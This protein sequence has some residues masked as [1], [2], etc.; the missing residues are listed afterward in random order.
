MA[1]FNEIPDGLGIIASGVSQFNLIYNGDYKSTVC[2]RDNFQGA[3]NQVA[4]V[5]KN[6]SLVYE[7]NGESG[8][9]YGVSIGVYQFDVPQ[10][11]PIAFLRQSK[12]EISYTG[13]NLFGSKV[14]LDGVTY[15]FFWGRVTLTITGDFGKLSY[16]SWN[17][18]YLGGFRRLDYES[19]CRNTSLNRSKSADILLTN[20]STPPA[21]TARYTLEAS[22]VDSFLASGTATVSVRRVSTSSGGVLAGGTSPG[23]KNP[24]ISTAQIVVGGEAS[25]LGG[26]LSNPI[27]RGGKTAGLLSSTGG[28]VVWQNVNNVLRENELQSTTILFDSTSGSSNYLYVSNFNLDLPEF[29]VPTGFNVRIKKSS[30]IG[31]ITDE[32]VG[33][34]YFVGGS[35]FITTNK[36]TGDLWPR[37]STSV[38]YGGSGDSWG[39]SWTRA[40]IVDPTFGILL[41]VLGDPAL[42]SAGAVDYIELSVY[43]YQF[44]NQEG[45]GGGNVSGTA[46]C[47]VVVNRSVSGGIKSSGIA[48]NIYPNINASGGSLLS[49]IADSGTT[50]KS[51]EG[52]GLIGGSADVQ[53]VADGNSQSVVLLRLNNPSGTNENIINNVTVRPIGPKWRGEWQGSY[54][55]TAIYEV[56]YPGDIVSYDN[57]FYICIGEIWNE[58]LTPLED[59]NDYG[60]TQWAAYTGPVSYVFGNEHGRYGVVSGVYKFNVPSTHPI[61]F[62]NFGRAAIQFVGEQPIGSKIASDGRTYTFYYGIVTLTI[63]T[64]WNRVA[65]SYESWA[66][67]YLGGLNNIIYSV[68]GVGQN[69]DVLLGGTSNANVSADRSPEGG[70]TCSGTSIVYLEQNQ[71]IDSYGVLASGE[72]D[73]VLSVAVGGVSQLGGSSEV[74]QYFDPTVLGGSKVGGAAVRNSNYTIAESYS[75]IVANGSGIIGIQPKTGE[76]SATLNGFIEINSEL[77]PVLVG[78]AKVGGSYIL[79]QTYNS[80]KMTGYGRLSGK[81][82]TERLKKLVKTQVSYG[83]S[84]ATSNILNTPIED[85][86]KIL[87]SADSEQPT[88]VESTSYRLQ[89][90]PGWCDIGDSCDSAYLPPIVKSRQGKYLPNKNKRS[91]ASRQIATLTEG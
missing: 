22:A 31:D 43:Y 20:P 10:A 85:P 61:A 59:I 34:V 5:T 9:L 25:I 83:L 87:I 82:R 73:R 17:N 13:Q 90:E 79:Q 69:T 71:T 50:I 74:T 44:I 45:S 91:V 78:F 21:I 11:Y 16:Q 42:S 38:N 19:T 1:I 72:A 24:I 2:L 65:F 49:G 40:E 37:V 89:H 55:F 62:H 6:G 88:E 81:A 33:L 66:N 26:S 7:I 51:I 28:G 48:L 36:A 54:P 75:G 53:F 63:S 84:M 32:L 14:G 58:S 3:V 70:I 56:N 67:G 27:I 12:P 8:G 29:A 18:G 77:S 76:G 68:A 64:G 35:P 4:V 86:N 46:T 39:K 47:N 60:G 57:N 52:M 80:L 15:Q 23:V 30:S 41:S